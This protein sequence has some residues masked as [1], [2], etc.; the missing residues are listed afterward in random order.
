MAIDPKKV[1]ERFAGIT[2]TYSPADVERLRGSY[3]VEHTVARLGAERLWELLHTEDYV[4]S[5]GAMTGNQAM[6]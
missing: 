5:L 6:Q 1:P 3:K 4:N 2:R